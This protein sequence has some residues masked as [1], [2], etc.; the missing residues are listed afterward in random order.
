MTDN[1]AVSWGYL[2][3]QCNTLLGLSNPSVSKQIGA[4]VIK[5]YAK[6]GSTKTQVVTNTYFINSN[7]KS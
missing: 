5:A 7:L 3:K 2:T 6:K 1:S 4:T